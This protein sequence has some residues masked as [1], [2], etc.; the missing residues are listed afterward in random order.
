MEFLYAGHTKTE[1]KKPKFVGK[2]WWYRQQNFGYMMGE[3][4]LLHLN[5]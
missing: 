1:M 2:V 5:I 3:E 4:A